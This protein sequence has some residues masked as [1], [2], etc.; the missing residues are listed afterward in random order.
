[1][2]YLENAKEES[3]ETIFNLNNELYKLKNKKII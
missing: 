1:M 2:Q 3:P